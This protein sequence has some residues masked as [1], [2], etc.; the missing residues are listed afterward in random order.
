MR[1]GWGTGTLCDAHSA[2]VARNMSETDV[3]LV[4]GKPVGSEPVRNDS[5][6]VKL[7]ELNLKQYEQELI[8]E[9][10]YDSVETLNEMSPDELT[11]LADDCKMKPGH[12]KKF[13]AAFAKT[14][15]AKDVSVRNSATAAIEAKPADPAVD[16]NM[17]ALKEQNEEM[18]EPEAAA[19]APEAVVEPEAAAEE[20][21]VAAEEPAAEAAEPEAAE[22]AAAPAAAEPEEVAGP[23]AE[24]EAPEAVAEPVA[25]AAEA[26][27]TEAEATEAEAEA[28]ATEAEAEAEAEAAEPEAEPEPEAVAEEPEAE[29]EEPEEEEKN[30]VEEKTPAEKAAEE[31]A[32]EEKAAEEM[33]VAAKKAAAEA[34]VY[35]FEVGEGSPA[36][37]LVKEGDLVLTINGVKVTDAMQG[38]EI[39]ASVGDVVFYVVRG[40]ELVTVTMHKTQAA[41]GVLFLNMRLEEIVDPMLRKVGLLIQ[42]LIGTDEKP[43][44]EWKMMTSAVLKHWAGPINNSFYEGITP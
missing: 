38:R 19:E 34:A 31:E 12:K 41:I 42:D 22:P 1:T 6:S 29:A 9:Q 27:A 3:T 15:E 36:S 30:K 33:K 14:A 4:M 10:G 16:P 35:V 18:E 26:E 37:G 7:Q 13:L 23:E 20:P 24:T 40:E 44:Q 39:C 2:P 11:Q 28:E 17:I 21:A 8:D 5:V 43:K 32:A 25:E